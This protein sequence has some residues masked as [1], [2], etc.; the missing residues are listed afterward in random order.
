MIDNNHDLTI[1]ELDA[2]SGG[3]KGVIYCREC[4]EKTKE[5]KAAK[6]AK[7][8]PSPRCSSNYCNSTRKGKA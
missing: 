2:V 1:R 7:R 3:I 6:A 5:A 8:T 4:A